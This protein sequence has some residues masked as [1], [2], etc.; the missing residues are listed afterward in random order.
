MQPIFGVIGC[1]TLGLVEEQ[2][3]VLFVLHPPDYGIS[4]VVV[5]VEGNEITEKEHCQIYLHMRCGQAHA[6]RT[7]EHDDESHCIKEEKV[8]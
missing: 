5:K 2:S 8:I 7:E 6:Q 3:A 1:S 4:P